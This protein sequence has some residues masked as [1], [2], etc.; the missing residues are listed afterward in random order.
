MGRM[1]APFVVLGAVAIG[2]AESVVL[3]VG[4]GWV[5]DGN[6]TN[7]MDSRETLL[8]GDQMRSGWPDE[9]SACGNR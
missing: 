9:G 3:V 1:T 2:A 4:G 8:A 6:L 7:P 5:V